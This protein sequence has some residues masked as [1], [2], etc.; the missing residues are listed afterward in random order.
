[1]IEEHKEKRLMIQ[2]EKKYDYLRGISCM[3][4]VLLHVSSSYWAVVGIESS[5]FVIMTIYNGLTRFAVPVF[6]MLSGGFLLEHKKNMNIKQCLIR[7]GKYLLNF[8]IWSA[9]YAFQGIVKKIVI[10]EKITQTLWDSSLE[11]FLWG[12]YHMWFV[13]LILGF[14]LML[15]ILRKLS[16][17]KT[18]IEYF[19]ILWIVTRFIIP[20][21]SSIEK[22]NFINI[23]I[24]KLEINMLIG[25]MG[26]FILGYYIKEYAIS[27]KLR[28][29]IYVGG[30][31]SF[32]Y[33]L[34]E[35]IRQSYIQGVCVENY[36]SPSSWNVLLFS[37]AIF[38]L[39]TYLKRVDTGYFL[40][41]KVAKG[42]FIIYMI[43]P[44]FIEKLNL[45]GVTTISFNCLWSIP[46]LTM[47]VFLCSVLVADV[48][49]R[50]PF[51]KKFL[52]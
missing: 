29:I 49:K 40:V 33:S 10:G 14:Y 39:F 34:I 4:I 5:E 25:Y 31:L 45:I 50:I 20:S 8:Y 7:F 41:E 32:I 42:S 52:L 46:L 43:H 16:E 21:I 1:M 24:G 38:T 22:L 30:I 26:Y 3:A 6:M 27:L 15:P 19:L 23:W 36:F 35:T 17:N 18:V 9:F 37:T 11:R 28:V 47:V 51:V 2:R 12:H 13:Y 44:F 48:I